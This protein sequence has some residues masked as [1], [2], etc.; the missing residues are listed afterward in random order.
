MSKGYDM[1]VITR[2]VCMP[3]ALPLMIVRRSNDHL[4]S[5]TVEALTYL[6]RISTWKSRGRWYV[7]AQ[8]HDLRVCALVNLRTVIDNTICYT[9]TRGK[10]ELPLSSSSQNLFERQI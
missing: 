4:S 9:F 10:V 8:T 7:K 1:A 2:L 5:Q 3:R 6:E